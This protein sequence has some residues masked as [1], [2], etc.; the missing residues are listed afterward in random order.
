MVT[1]QSDDRRPLANIFLHGVISCALLFSLLRSWLGAALRRLGKSRSYQPARA[2]LKSLLG[3]GQPVRIVSKRLPILRRA[4]A[5]ANSKTRGARY[6]CGR[7][8]LSVAFLAN[9]RYSAI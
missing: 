9:E 5:A 3:A 1:L 8:S 2:T 6:M 7:G 4:I